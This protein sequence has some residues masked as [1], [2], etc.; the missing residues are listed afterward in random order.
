M[1][2]RFINIAVILILTLLSV[3]LAT[4]IYWLFFPYKTADIV[5]PIK[6]LNDNHEIAHNEPIKMELHITK[7]EL[8]PVSTTNTITCG[9]LI[10]V[11]GSVLP[12]GSTTLPKGSYVR[13]QDAYTMPGD[14][15]VGASCEFVFHNEYEVN[16]IR[17]VIKEWRSESFTVKD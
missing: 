13:L 4:A 5:E 3:I 16:P 17:T 9:S 15:P 2:L 1:K 12:K 8:Y 11:I 7:Y 10:Y 6:V 14:A